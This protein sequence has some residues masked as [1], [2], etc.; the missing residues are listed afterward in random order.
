MIPYKKLFKNCPNISLLHVFR[1]VYFVHDFNAF[2]NKLD[3]K[4]IGCMF[5]GYDEARKG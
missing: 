4:S 2:F 5:H 1:C 3:K